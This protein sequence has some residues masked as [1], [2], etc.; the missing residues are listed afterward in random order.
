MKT[1]MNNFL[2]YGKFKFPL[3]YFKLIDIID[4]FV[5]ITEKLQKFFIIQAVDINLE[6]KS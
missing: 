5:K 4:N 1:K 6:S 2:N 3:K